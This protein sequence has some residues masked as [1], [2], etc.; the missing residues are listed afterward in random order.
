MHKCTHLCDSRSVHLESLH[1]PVA[2]GDGHNKP[3]GDLVLSHVPHNVKLGSSLLWDGHIGNPLQFVIELF[4]EIF[5][6][7]RNQL[8]SK[9]QPLVAIVIAVVHLGAVMLRSNHPAKHHSQVHT[10]QSKIKTG[11]GNMR[12]D[13]SS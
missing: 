5:K 6:Q 11:N 13:D 1:R 12:E 10:F 7:Q 3:I 9:L 4:E 2:R 8:P